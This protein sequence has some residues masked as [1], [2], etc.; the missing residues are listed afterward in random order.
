LKE[1]N[2]NLESWFGLSYFRKNG[3]NPSNLGCKIMRSEMVSKD[4]GAKDYGSPFIHDQTFRWTYSHC[5][6]G[7]I[8]LIHKLHFML[9]IS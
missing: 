3:K 1:S 6:R 9:S 4:M 8:V 5:C 7:G 2:E